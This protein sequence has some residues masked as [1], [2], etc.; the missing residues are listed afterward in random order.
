MSQ[1]R[2]A[3]SQDLHS[4]RFL[5]P[6]YAFRVELGNTLL[7]KAHFPEDLPRV[8]AQQRSRPAWHDLGVPKA[9][10]VP[11]HAQL[12][13]NGMLVCRRPCRWP[14]RADRR[15]RSRCVLQRPGRT[16]HLPACRRA[17]LSCQ[18]SGQRSAGPGP[19]PAA[20]RPDGSLLARSAWS[21]TE[22][23]TVEGLAEG[24]A[25]CWRLRHH[26][27]PA[28]VRLIQPVEGI[29]AI[30]PLIRQTARRLAQRTCVNH[31]ELRRIPPLSRLVSTRCTKPVRSLT[32][33]ARIV[34][35]APKAPAV[36]SVGAS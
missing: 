19:G 12:S 2:P 33:R 32:N 31:S 34:P 9:Y 4:H 5:G 1:P 25:L 24:E 29:E 22:V 7:G 17:R 23:L 10:I 36:K 26:V 16:G 27:K 3:G 30:L 20:F 21:R 28:V 13:Q 18:A 8:L 15:E 35:S 6:H 11:G 14:R